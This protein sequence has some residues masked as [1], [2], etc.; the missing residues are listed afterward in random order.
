MDH[1]TLLSEE[2]DAGAKLAIRFNEYMPVETAFWLNPLDEGRWLLYIASAEITDSNISDAYGEV[3][4][5]VTEMETP[6]LDPFQVTLIGS[7]HR[8]AKA[9]LEIN[10][11][12]PSPMANRIRGTRFGGVGVEEVYLYPTRAVTPVS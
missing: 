8:L 9:A 10:R 5:I 1:R 7:D 3:I 6:Y 11:R 4:R 12:Y 2:T